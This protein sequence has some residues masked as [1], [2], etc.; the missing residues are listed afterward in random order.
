MALSP[1]AGADGWEGEPSRDGPFRISEL[2]AR[3]VDPAT[4]RE[5]SVLLIVPQPAPEE[6]PAPLVL[7]SPGFLLRGD[8]YRSYGQR[9]ASHGIIAA[10]LTYQV[11]LFSADHRLLL[12]DLL[13]VLDRLLAPDGP[14]AGRAD[15]SRVGTAGHSLGGKLSLLAASANERVRAVGA[16]DPVDSGPPGGGDPARFPS[17]TPELMDRIHAPLLLVGAEL[18]GVAQFGPPC[19]PAEENYQRF[20]EAALPPA[21]EVT[22]LDAGHMQYLDNPDCGLLCAVCVR[23]EAPSDEIR[24]AAQAYLTAFFLGHLAGIPGALAWLDRKLAEDEASGQILVRRK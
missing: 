10:M 3:L 17:V 1:L 4:A 15:P 24:A 21:L 8:Q 23:G 5:V 22:Q 13:F 16:L 7:F 2:Q 6:A 12:G 9:L 11:S 14:L 20:F 18:G 19:A